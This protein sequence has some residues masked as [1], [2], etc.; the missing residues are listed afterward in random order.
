MHG[1]LVASD[2]EQACEAVSASFRDKGPVDLVTVRKTYLA[3]FNGSGGNQVRY[4]FIFV[5]VGFL[6]PEPNQRPGQADCRSAVKRLKE[7]LPRAEVVVMCP[8]TRTR[9]AVIAVKGGMGSYLSY[10]IDPHEV[11][12]LQERIEERQRKQ[13]ELNYLRNGFWRNES[14]AIVKTRSPLMEKVFEQVRSVAD[15]R[16]TVLLGGES[17]TGKGVIARL[18]HRDSARADG[19]FVSVHCGAIP[20]TLIESELFGHERGAFT[21][22]DRRKLGKFEIAKG[23][24]I[25]LDEIGTIT[26]SAQIKLLEVLQSQTF[27]R[28]GGEATIEADARIIA[29]TNED[30]GEL[31]RKGLFR[32]DLYYRLNV[33]PIFLPS[34]RQRVEDLEILA[35]EFL[36]RLNRLYAKKVQ[37]IDPEVM[38]AFRQYSWP[39]N[40]RELENLME[41]AYILEKSDI[42]TRA[43]FPVELFSLPAVVSDEPQPRTPTMKEARRK[44]LEAIEN[45]Y[46]REILSVERGSIGRTAQTAGITTRQLNK[47]M[48]K[49]G[50]RKEEFR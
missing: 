26:Q 30:L 42:L 14:F 6:D 37:A 25:F 44:G 32:T 47:L 11:T 39:G 45:K 41:R 40:I 13:L 4:D 18:I 36:G 1:I 22:A 17:G 20:D 35:E 29:A 10:P 19:P 34:L 31:T 46:L 9:D 16:S 12:H 21:G 23:G 2:C 3:L 43:G 38:D 33:F 48:S 8:P 15:C 49:Y 5:D 7:R 27:H 50:L 28:V 24:S